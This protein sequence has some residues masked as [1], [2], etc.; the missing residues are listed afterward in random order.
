MIDVHAVMTALSQ[1]RPAFHS[2][3]DFQHAFAWRIQLWYP[4]LRI[5]LEYPFH[6]QDETIDHLDIV[7]FDEKGTTAFEMKYKTAPFFAPLKEDVFYLKGHSAQ[8]IGRYDFLRDVYRVER[9]VAECRN[10]AGY[11]IL[12][13]NDGAYW[14]P[15]NRGRSVC[16]QFRLTD[17]RVITGELSWSET[18]GKGTT[19]GREVPIR[20]K[21]S[22]TCE[23]RD[24]SEFRMSEYTKGCG[25]FRYLAIGIA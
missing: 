11:A 5:R 7:A 23:W 25:R 3:A 19:K 9:Y 22:Y 16:D 20:L 10:S 12:L 17:K 21:G 4:D 24:Y 6:R 8:D 2:E 14:N 18:A 15:S 1:D 13:T